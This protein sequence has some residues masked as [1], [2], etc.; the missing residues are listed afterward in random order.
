MSKQDKDYSVQFQELQKKI[1]DI[2]SKKY[3]KQPIVGASDGF[4]K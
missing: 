2:D 3:I 4:Q 1:I